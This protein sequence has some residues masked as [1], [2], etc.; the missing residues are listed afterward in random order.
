MSGEMIAPKQPPQPSM[1]SRMRDLDPD[2]VPTD[3]GILP[4]TFIKPEGKDMP[5]FFKQP[6]ERLFFEWTW[7]KTWVT[8]AFA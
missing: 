5:D 1:I 8:S 2:K 7:L 6:K 3:F 4:G